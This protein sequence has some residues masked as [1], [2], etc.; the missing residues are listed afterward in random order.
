MWWRR[1][2]TYQ[3]SFTNETGKPFDVFVEPYSERYE[4]QPGDYLTVIYRGEEEEPHSV[5][6]HSD[7][8]IIWPNG[9]LEPLVEINGKPA[10]PLPDDSAT[11]A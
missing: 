9:V 10:T 6:M 1:P 4:L 2:K 7:H 8:L 5:Y 11:S 3:Q